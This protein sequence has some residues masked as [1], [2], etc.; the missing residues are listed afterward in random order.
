MKRFL[1]FFIL[2]LSLLLCSK[3]F[4]LTDTE[5]V[6]SFKQYVSD[7][8]KKVFVSYEGTHYNVSYVESNL[9]FWFK[10]YHKIDQNYKIDVEKTTS[11]ISPYVGT[12]QVEVYYNTSDKFPTKKT[13]EQ[14][15]TYKVHSIQTFKITLAYQEN[16]WVVTDAHFKS[17]SLDSVIKQDKLSIYENL[18]CP[19]KIRLTAQ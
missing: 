17:S 4:A 13:A 18:K 7:E 12:L 16:K 11:L 5:V 10:S 8:M 1:V 14:A 6:D 15:T 9:N 2:A 19:D 3:V